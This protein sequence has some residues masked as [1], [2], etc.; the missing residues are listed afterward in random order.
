MSLANKL[1]FNCTHGKEDPERASLPFVAGNVAATSGQVSFSYPTGLG[2]GSAQPHLSPL[3]DEVGIDLREG[4]KSLCYDAICTSFRPKPDCLN[5]AEYDGFLSCGSCDVTRHE[6]QGGTLRVVLSVSAVENEFVCQTHP[7][8]P[9][10]IC[11]ICAFLVIGTGVT[12]E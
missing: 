10:W 5:R 6:G 12:L 1:I 8:T 9:F 11:A 2:T 3:P 7:L 4:I